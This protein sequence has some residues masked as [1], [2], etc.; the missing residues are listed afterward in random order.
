MYYFFPNIRVLISINVDLTVDMLQSGNSNTGKH[1]HIMLFSLQVYTQKMFE[2]LVVSKIVAVVG[3]CA[4]LPEACIQINTRN[5]GVDLRC[6]D[7]A[8]AFYNRSNVPLKDCKLQC[9]QRSNCVGI[10]YNHVRNY[11]LCFSSLCALT[12]PDDEFI[13]LRYVDR[14]VSHDECLRWLPF[15]DTLP[16]GGVVFIRSGTGEI[17]QLLARGSIDQAVIPGKLLAGRLELISVYNGDNPW[18]TDNI[19][20]LDIHPS[21]F[22]VWTYYD[23]RSGLGLPS[24]AVQGGWLTDGTPLYVAQ[25]SG[26]FGY[27]NPVS[28]KASISF[29]GVVNSRTMDILVVVWPRWLLCN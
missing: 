27:Y 20:Y 24:G 8:V 6:E 5:T 23:S 15:L 28:G 2:V 19:E 25:V 17:K 3:L 1:D 14:V 26:S 16:S 9:I 7:H 29:G 4:Y 11:C 10:N 21:C 22:G 18:I 12:Q 13:M